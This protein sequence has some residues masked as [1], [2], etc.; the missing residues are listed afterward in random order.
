MCAAI[1]KTRND[2]RAIFTFATEF[3]DGKFTVRD[4]C[5]WLKRNV[6]P[7]AIYVVLLASI[8]VTGCGYGNFSSLS[9]KAF[10]ATANRD[11]VTLRSCLAN[12]SL[13]VNFRFGSGFDNGGK[14]L[15]HEA[16]DQ[17]YPEVVQLLLDSH[18]NPDIQDNYGETPLIILMCNAAN[19]ER[20]RCLNILLLSGANITIQNDQGQDALFVAAMLGFDE[21]VA[22]LLAKGA[23]VDHQSKHGW[24][25]LHI[26][27]TGSDRKHGYIQIA[28]RLIKAGA[29]RMARDRQGRTPLDIAI[30]GNNFK[31]IKLLEGQ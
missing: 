12:P 21:Y 27:A 10:H 11:L 8:L 17:G 24:T 6:G 4:K 25:P 13:D 31:M 23:P 29:D 18:A 7:F 15:L 14:T 28:K 1:N 19:E 30:A 22:S 3:W 26:V 9:Q 5:Q 16:C 20:L 2:L